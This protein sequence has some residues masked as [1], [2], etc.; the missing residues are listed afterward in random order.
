MFQKTII[1]GIVGVLVCV[2]SGCSVTEPPASLIKKPHL[3]EN[4]AAIQTAVKEN[5]P[6]KAKLIAPLDSKHKEKIILSDL[7]HDGH[8]EVIFFYTDGYSPV[9]VAV[10]K[11]T[12]HKWKKEVDYKSDSQNIDDFILK[13]VTHDHKPELLVGYRHDAYDETGFTYPDNKLAV[14]QF[15]DKKLKEIMKTKYSNVVVNDLNQDG[16]NDVTIVYNKK[17]KEASAAVYQYN[18]GKMQKLSALK[19]DPNVNGYLSVK[20]GNI[21]EKKKG[22]VI[23]A[24]VGAHSS[25]THL[26]YFKG[27]KLVSYKENDKLFNPNT[28]ESKDAN[29]DGI[30]DI[31]FSVTPKGWEDEAYAFVPFLT[32]Y[33]EWS[34][35]GLHLIQESY[36]NYGLSLSIVFPK[37]WQNNVTIKRGSLK[38]HIT[39]ITKNKQETLLKV[40][41]FKKNKWHESEKWIKAGESDEYVYAVP[42]IDKYKKYINAIH[43]ID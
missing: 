3:T 18:N 37:K 28:M 31:G 21:S 13:D 38:H 19:L 27:G 12:G 2:L 41:W 17:R 34:P 36:D 30:I 42:N 5:M 25:F 1:V 22:L 15:K 24:G 40:Y 4:K 29:H 20:V 11:Q 23:D 10:L 43:V 39:F 32:E 7:D 14:Y 35:S 9:H 33:K 6:K 26:F 16:Q 8:K